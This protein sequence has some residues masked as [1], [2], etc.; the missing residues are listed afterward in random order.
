MRKLAFVFAVL[1][2]AVL[3]ASP[4]LAHHEHTLHNPARSVTFKCEPAAAAAVHPIH[5]G[6]HVGIRDRGNGPGP[7]SVSADEDPGCQY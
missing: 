5:N 1:M 7:V 3:A 2:L 6:L 4:A